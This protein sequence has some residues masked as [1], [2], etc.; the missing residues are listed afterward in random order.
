[1]GSLW[2][3]E[4]VVLTLMIYCL[5]GLLNAFGLAHA[6]HVLVDCASRLLC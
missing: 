6:N 5:V 3:V 1:V 2:V 4:C